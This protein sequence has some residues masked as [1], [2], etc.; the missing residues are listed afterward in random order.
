MKTDDY[1]CPHVIII[2][3]SVQVKTRGSSMMKPDD[4]ETQDDGLCN[5][6][7]VKLLL[8]TQRKQYLQW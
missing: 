3:A 8:A 1:S 6:T 4:D 2:N 5:K 7:R